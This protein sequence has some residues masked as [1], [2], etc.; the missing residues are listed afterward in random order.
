MQLVTED[1]SLGFHFLLSSLG[2]FFSVFIEFEIRLCTLWSPS[3]LQCL[4][5]LRC[6]GLLLY[7]LCL[8]WILLYFRLLLL[9]QWCKLVQ[10]DH[11]TVYYYLNRLLK[12][13]SLQGRIPS[14]IIADESLDIRIDVNAIDRNGH[15]EL[16]TLIEV[17]A[18]LGYIF[19]ELVKGVLEKLNEVLIWGLQLREDRKVVLV[20][21]DINSH[22]QLS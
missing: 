8:H 18:Y 11:L 22:V 6:R 13:L 10:F 3:S 17:A 4:F 12:L 21:S 20:E 2:L 7:H 16:A 1:Q 15:L 19:R 9:P 5:Y 14:L